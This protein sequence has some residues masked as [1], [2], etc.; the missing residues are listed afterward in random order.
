M[1][2]LWIEAEVNW[3]PDETP[4]DNANTLFNDGFTLV[5]VRSSYTLTDK[6]SIYGEVSNVFDETYASAT[7]LVDTVSSP[8]QAVFLPGD[9]RAFVAGMK[10]K[11]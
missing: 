7:L 2:G 4:V 6:L 1:Q 11:F 5:D 9:G 3:L 10:A 8:N